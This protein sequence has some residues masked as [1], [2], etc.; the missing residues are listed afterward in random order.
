MIIGFFF[1]NKDIVIVESFQ[2][3]RKNIRQMFGR[4]NFLHYVCKQK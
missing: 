1:I 4:Y 2:A 3:K